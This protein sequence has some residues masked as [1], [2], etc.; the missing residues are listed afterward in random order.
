MGCSPALLGARFSVTGAPLR[1]PLAAAARLRGLADAHGTGLAFERQVDR[2]RP[3]EE[4]QAERAPPG[5]IDGDEPRMLARLEDQVVGPP[6]QGI[7]RAQPM[8]AGL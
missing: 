3:E 8:R 5:T 1:M 6:E 2:H 4:Q 7:V